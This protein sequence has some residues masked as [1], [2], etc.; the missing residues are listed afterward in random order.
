[1]TKE[2]TILSKLGRTEEMLAGLAAHA[3]QLARRG[4]DA[5]FI[6]KLTTAH[7]NAR[8]AHT[9]QL[10]FKARMMEKT[11]EC[12]RRLDEMLDLYSEARKQVKIELPTETWRE[13]GIVNQR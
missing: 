5:A 10:A 2:Q 8:D 7:G 4:I 3:E 12:Q 1:V 13:F 6:T 9:E 11:N